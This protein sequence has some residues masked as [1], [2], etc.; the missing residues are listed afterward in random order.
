MLKTIRRSFKSR[1]MYVNEPMKKQSSFFLE[2]NEIHAASTL[3]KKTVY[4]SLKVI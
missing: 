1:E 2:L 3:F 4:L